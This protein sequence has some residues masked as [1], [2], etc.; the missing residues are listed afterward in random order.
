MIDL[1]NPYVMHSNGILRKC[2]V[3]CHVPQRLTVKVM[4]G[5]TQAGG[6]R[7]FVLTKG[8]NEFDIAVEVEEHD[9]L[10]FTMEPL[11]E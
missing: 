7:V 10:E 3:Y 4:R 11:D 8:A 1:G 5:E 2:R 9:R 6:D